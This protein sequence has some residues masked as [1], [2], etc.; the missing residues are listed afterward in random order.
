MIVVL[1]SLPLVDFEA[2][3]TARSIC[4]WGQMLLHYIYLKFFMVGF[5]NTRT[6]MAPLVCS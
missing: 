4:Y 6:V 3:S 1:S 2:D 5:Y